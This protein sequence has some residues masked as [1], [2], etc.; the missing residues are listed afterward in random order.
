[1][2]SYKVNFSGFE[3]FKVLRKNANIVIVLF[4]KQ[5]FLTLYVNTNLSDFHI[6]EDGQSY[7][8]KSSDIKNNFKNDF[9]FLNFFLKNIHTGFFIKIKF[10]GKGFR[11]QSFKKKKVINFTFG[12]SHMYKVFMQDLFFKRLSKYK[13]FF[14]TKNIFLLNNL[15][16]NLLKIKPLNEYTLRGLRLA[17]YTVVK[18]KGRKS[19][20]I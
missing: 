4:I 18:R 16:I 11:I 2:I 15:K 12:H 20:N 14:K 7:T 3:N 19:P 13:Y 10:I 6:N 5:L 9:K 17:K 8:T 1:L